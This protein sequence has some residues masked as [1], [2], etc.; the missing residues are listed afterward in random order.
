MTWRRLLL[1]SFA[2]LPVLAVLLGMGMWQLQRLGWKAG[3]LERLAEAQVGPPGPAV[4]PAPFAHIVASG[5]FRHDLEVLL[6][7]EVRGRCW[8]PR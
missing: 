6:G 7:S 1:P 3:V 4:V 5:R 8:G 2:A